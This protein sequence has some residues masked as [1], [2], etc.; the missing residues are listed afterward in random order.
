MSRSLKAFALLLIVSF[1]GTMVVRYLR[2]PHHFNPGA[3]SK[4][5][6]NKNPGRFQR[7]GQKVDRWLGSS[8]T[9]GQ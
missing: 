7:A 6:S 8:D 5:Q 1:Y 3:N 2:H 4:A 9:K